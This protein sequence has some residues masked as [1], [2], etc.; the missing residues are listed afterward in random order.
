MVNWLG[1]K[2]KR[3]GRRVERMIKEL[4][5]DGYLFV[6]KKGGTVSLNPSRGQEISEYVEKNPPK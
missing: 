4:V 2:V 6:H 1:K 5:R 3:N